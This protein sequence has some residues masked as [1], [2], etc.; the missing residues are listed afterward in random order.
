MGSKSKWHMPKI[1]EQ[2]AV[3]VQQGAR[4]V[5]EP[6]ITVPHLVDH[7]ILQ[8]LAHFLPNHF[9]DFINTK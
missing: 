5:N 8:D 4:L 7:L 3:K 1:N 6:K 2:P 9:V